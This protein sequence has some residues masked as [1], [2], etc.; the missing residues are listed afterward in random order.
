M[1]NKSCAKVDPQ[2]VVRGEEGGAKGATAPSP[3]LDL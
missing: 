2:M 1:S 3:I